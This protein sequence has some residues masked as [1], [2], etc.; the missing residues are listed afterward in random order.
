LSNPCGCRSPLISESAAIIL[1][2]SPAAFKSIHDRS[3][4]VSF[5][6]HRYAPSDA[7]GP[8]WWRSGAR[9]SAPQLSG[10]TASPQHGWVPCPTTYWTSTVMSLSP[11]PMCSMSVQVR[12]FPPG[13]IPEY[14]PNKRI[15][16]GGFLSRP[17]RLIGAGSSLFSL[18]WYDC[19][20]RVL[21]SRCQSARSR[22]DSREAF[23]RGRREAKCISRD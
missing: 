9:G 1:L 5:S 3:L 6:L 18:K 10:V 11:L 8:T 4:V 12:G 17:N 16:A 13:A 15:D 21:G 2:L 19:Q 22:S 20:I 23:P 7:V 14:K